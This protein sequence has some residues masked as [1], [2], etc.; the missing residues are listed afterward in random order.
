MRSLLII[1]LFACSLSLEAKP[2]EWTNVLG[3][4]FKGE[5]LQ[6]LGPMALF[7]TSSNS[8]RWELFRSLSVETVRRFYREAKLADPASRWAD[9]KADATAALVGRASRL[10]ADGKWTKVDFTQVPEPQL[11]LVLYGPRPWGESVTVALA[12]QGVYAHLQS[13]RPGQVEFVFLGD[14]GVIAWTGMPWYTAG[15][16]D[17]AEMRTLARYAPKEDSL[18][19]LMTRNG[20]VLM[21]ERGE[22]YG[23]IT[24]FLDTV[25]DLL[26]KIDPANTDYWLDR[27]HYLQSVRPIEHAQD[28]SPPVLLGLP[29]KPAAIRSL[30]I[31]KIAATLQVDASGKTTGVEW[32]VDS[33]VPES[34]QGRV[35]EALMH[36]HFAPAIDQGVATPAAFA[37]AWDVPEE[38]SRLVAERAWYS[39]KSQSEIPITSWLVLKPI[40]IPQEEFSLSGTD[41]TNA[42]GTVVLQAM[43]VSAGITREIQVNAFNSNWFDA[44]GAGSVQPA[45]GN[46]QEVDGTVCHWEKVAPDSGYVNL[47]NGFDN[48]DYSVGYAWTEVDVPNETD[49]LFGIGSDDGIKIWVNGTLVHDQ[50]VQRPC[51]LDEDIVP[52]RLKKGKNTILIKIQNMKGEWGY[53]CRLRPPAR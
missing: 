48:C 4:S 52:L 18:I 53:G 26:W 24:K 29:F 7:R 1:L 20:Q 19:V 3:T 21:S 51:K 13:L 41:H 12:P 17:L 35:K 15:L 23:T 27:L 45:A 28:L 11:L 49:A 6:A 25:C 42:D 43:K 39:T 16:D 31:S 34:R 14:K 10:G 32:P 40:P 9:T 50:W 5:P 37:F 22:N 30:G 47:A 2:S 36:A 33:G 44:A 38:T 8:V 46:R